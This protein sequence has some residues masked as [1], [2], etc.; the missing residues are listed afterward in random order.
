MP[1]LLCNNINLEQL[2]IMLN[3]YDMVVRTVA[4]GEHI[5][6]SFWQPPEAGLVGNTLYV[7]DDT[8]VHSAL[9]E[10]C[11]YICMDSQR[12]ETLD[13]DAGGGYD[14]E[15]A[16]CY[17]Q[18]MLSKHIVEMGRQR[19]FSDMD[20]WGYSFRLGSSQ[21]WFEQ[22]AEDAVEWLQLHGLIDDNIQSA[23]KLRQ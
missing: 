1:V 14:E 9:H 17:L 11:H 15:D 19:M 8:P 3:R 23:W 12:R 20:A 16:V 13:T 10:A 22:D 7:R 4:Q 6:G 21:A 18:I 5:P 2:E